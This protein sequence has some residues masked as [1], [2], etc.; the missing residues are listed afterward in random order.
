MQTVYQNLNW[1]SALTDHE[2]V[3]ENV[4]EECEKPCIWTYHSAY[5]G[6]VLFLMLDRPLPKLYT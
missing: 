4:C 6:E 2:I 5:W 1:S 3:E